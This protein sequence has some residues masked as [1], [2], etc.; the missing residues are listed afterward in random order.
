M[1]DPYDAS[2]SWVGDEREAVRAAR[3]RAYRGGSRKLA[4]L[5]GERGSRWR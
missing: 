3:V 2:W 4:A 5:V 1:H